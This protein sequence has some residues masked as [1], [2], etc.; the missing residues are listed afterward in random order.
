MQRAVEDVYISG[1]IIDYIVD[2][3][4]A[5]EENRGGIEIESS[6]EKFLGTS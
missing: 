4:E 3:I 5:T 1:P 6:P 2:I